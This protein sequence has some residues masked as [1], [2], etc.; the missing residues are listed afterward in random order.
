MELN[1]MKTILLKAILM[2]QLNDFK[3]DYLGLFS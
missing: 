1:R 3:F 2:N